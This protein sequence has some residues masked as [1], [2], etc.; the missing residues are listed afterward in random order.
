MSILDII[1]TFIGIGAMAKDSA[2]EKSLHKDKYM[3]ANESQRQTYYVGGREFYTQTGQEV[4]TSFSADGHVLIKNISGD[5][6][7]DITVSRNKTKEEK[8]TEEGRSNGWIFHRKCSW[9]AP[10]RS[11]NVWVSDKYPGKY[12]HCW[13]NIPNSDSIL[14]EGKLEPYYDVMKV[15]TLTGHKNLRVFMDGTPETKEELRKRKNK[16]ARETAIKCGQTFYQ[17][18]DDK[19]NPVIRQIAD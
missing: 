7:E 17:A 15:N 3:K 12:F 8:L 1:N 4:Y 9:D 14:E 19:G 2:T 6:L 10:G 18:R 16:K 11:S 5:V 13:D